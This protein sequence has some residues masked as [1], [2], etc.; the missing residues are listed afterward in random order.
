MPYFNRTVVSGAS[1]YFEVS[2]PPK[3]MREPTHERPCESWRSSRWNRSKPTESLAQPSITPL[4]GSKNNA[5]VV[6]W[7]S[8]RRLFIYGSRI[9]GVDVLF[10]DDHP[11]H[12]FSNTGGTGSDMSLRAPTSLAEHS[13]PKDEG[14]TKVEVIGPSVA[15]SH[16]LVCYSRWGQT[17]VKPHPSTRYCMSDRCR[18][19]RAAGY[20][21]HEVDRS[22]LGS[23]R[24]TP[25]RFRIQWRR[26]E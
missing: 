14:R 4:P 13:Q 22:R 11:N 19:R 7:Y 5:A 2:I 23:E 25:V 12:I 10:T 3:I 20:H 9:G 1:L 16:S 17:S 8:R 26:T 21:H 24:G 6:V 18:G 15:V